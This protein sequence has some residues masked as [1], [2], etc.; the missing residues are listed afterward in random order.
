MEM[1]FKLL[2]REGRNELQEK[3]G[4]GQYEHTISRHK[5]QNE[6]RTVKYLIEEE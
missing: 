6:N 5:V 1:Y 2:L 3:K 4:T